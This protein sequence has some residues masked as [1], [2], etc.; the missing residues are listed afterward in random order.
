ML[1]PSDS[2]MR[3]LRVLSLIALAI[4]IWM[5]AQ[6]TSEGASIVDSSFVDWVARRE[7]GFDYNARGKLDELGAWQLRAIAVREVNRIFG[8]SY[9]HSDALDPVKGR[10][11]ATLYLRICESRSRSKTRAAVYRIYR[12]LR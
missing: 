5:L 1:T 7:S 8:T 4:I 12:G 9:V 10:R 6:R 2:D 11:I 3:A